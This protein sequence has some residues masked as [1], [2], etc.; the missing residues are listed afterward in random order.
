MK[1]KSHIFIL[2]FLNETTALEII[3]FPNTLINSALIEV[4]TDLQPFSLQEH[5]N[6]FFFKI[7]KKRRYCDGHASKTSQF[8]EEV[9]SSKIFSI[10]FFFFPFAHTPKTSM[11]NA[12]FSHFFRL[13]KEISQGNFESSSPFSL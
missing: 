10:V 6:L 3:L 8:M 9:R 5:F 4:L 13:G 2:A 1:G 7:K 12:I 11:K